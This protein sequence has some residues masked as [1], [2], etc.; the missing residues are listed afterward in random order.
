MGKHRHDEDRRQQFVA[1]ARKGMSSNA[2]IIAAA[3]IFVA[4]AI[5]A[6]RGGQ[7]GAASAATPPAGAGEDVSFPV[8]EFADGQARFY[9]YTST[10]GKEIRFFVMKSS[11]GVIRA[12][13]DSCDVCYRERRGYRQSGDSM[14][15]NNCG[16]AFA[17][18][19]INV[20]Q[21]G[22]NPA[23]I[24]RSVEGDRVVL[25]AAALEQGQ[26]YF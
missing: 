21:G 22:C 1:P 24:E 20:L 4:A 23:P 19:N 16:Q 15:C 9:R 12:A 14:I 2:L 3:L 7:S 26:F 13:F 25:R 6:T 8:G 5:F 17:S 11:D 10:T 18:R